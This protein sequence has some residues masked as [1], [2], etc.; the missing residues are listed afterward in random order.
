MTC[1]LFYLRLVWRDRIEF[2]FLDNFFFSK[3]K[4]NSCLSLRDLDK[5]MELPEGIDK[6]IEKIIFPPGYIHLIE[7]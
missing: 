4:F 6:L 3:A 2:D 7:F 1:F 5:T